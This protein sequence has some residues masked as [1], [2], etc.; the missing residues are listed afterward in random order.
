MNVCRW[1]GIEA[2]SAWGYVVP[3]L[4][5]AVSVFSLCVGISK[6]PPASEELLWYCSSQLFLSVSML[7]ARD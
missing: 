6:V 4:C 7:G 5:V 2:D 3:L 1:E